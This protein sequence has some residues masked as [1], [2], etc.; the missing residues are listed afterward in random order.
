MTGGTARRLFFALWPDAATRRRL[1]GVA[2]TGRPVAARNY[3]LTLAFLGPVPASRFEAVVAAARPVA[4]PPLS[5]ELDRYGGSRRAR[6]LWLEPARVPRP[7]V[8]LQEALWL[9][10]E[11]LGWTRESR[12]FRPHVTVAR[13][14]PAGIPDL[15]APLRWQ[16]RGFVLVESETAPSGARYRVVARYPAR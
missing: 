2:T 1:A 6:V 13:K 5:F 4:A 16:S 9:R 10:L 12:P 14:A 15:Q 11:P 3:H 7:L 8:H